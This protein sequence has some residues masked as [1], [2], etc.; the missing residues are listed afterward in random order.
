MTDAFDATGAG[1]PG[2]GSLRDRTAIIAL[3][4]GRHSRR[5]HRRAADHAARKYLGGRFTDISIDASH[6]SGKSV[7]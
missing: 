7:T 1:R 2:C 3:G 6:M 5:E 4:Y